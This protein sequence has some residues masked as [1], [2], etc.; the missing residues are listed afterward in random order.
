MQRD[1]LAAVSCVKILRDRLRR[2]ARAARDCPPAGVAA[3]GRRAGRVELDRLG[4]SIQHFIEVVRPCPAWRWLPGCSPRVWVPPAPV[5]G[6]W[7]MCPAR[8]PSRPGPDPRAHMAG[9]PAHAPRVGQWTAPEAAGPS[10]DSGPTDARLWQAHHLR[11]HRHPGCRPLSR[12]I[13][14]SAGM[15][16]L[17]ACSGRGSEQARWMRFGAAT[18]PC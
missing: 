11:D 10:G 9:S 14:L 17:G 2:A 7:S 12:C 3:S 16:T 13:A 4:C 8:P 18:V 1:A 6:C 5:A 15:V